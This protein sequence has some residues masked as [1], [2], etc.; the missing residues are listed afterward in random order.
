MRLEIR[1]PRV[2]E[3]SDE[4]RIAKWRVSVG[5]VVKTG[6]VVADVVVDMGTR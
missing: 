2:S 3:Y 1:M 5:A 6:D 4:G